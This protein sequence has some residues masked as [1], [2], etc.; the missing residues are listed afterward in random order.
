[1][2]DGA[3]ELGI[4]IGSSSVVAAICQTGPDA[5][6]SSEPVF[7][8]PLATALA[9]WTAGREL[10]LPATDPAISPIALL[11]RVGDPI[12]VQVAGRAAD[13]AD[14][15]AGVARLLVDR[16]TAQEG[17]PPARTAVVVPPSWGGHRRT[18]LVT[19]LGAVGLQDAVLVSAAVA[20]V[21]AHVES[22]ELP[23]DATAVVVDLGA[24]TSDVAVV[25]P[26]QDGELDHRAAPAAALR[27][28]GRDVDDA[29][30]RHVRRCL[31]L[32]TGPASAADR[33]RA[34]ALRAACTVAK[35]AAS[36]QTE[37]EVSVDPDW[38]ATAIRLTREELEGAI[39]D[40][41]ERVV[42][43]AIEAVAAAVTTAD[44]LSGV[45]LTGGASRM[46]LVAECLSDALAVPLY[47]A[48]D[49]AL[50]NARG[51]A[52][53]AADLG[54]AEAAV[55]EDEAVVGS[56][57]RVRHGR[58]RSG[59]ERH[60]DRPAAKSSGRSGRAANGGRAV[61][62]PA[63]VAVV[64]ALFLVLV[65]GPSLALA[66]V[67]AGPGVATDGTAAAGDKTA[68]DPATDPA[69]A[70]VTPIDGAA[71]TSNAGHQVDAPST[72]RATTHTTSGR[73][74]SRSSSSR[75]ASPATSS[76]KAATAATAGTATVPVTTATTT[77]PAT[78]A[79]DTTTTGTTTSSGPV[80]SSDPPPATTSD[81]PP[82]TSSDPP[83]PA[84]SSAPAPLPD[85]STS[86][87]STGTGTSTGTSSSS[88]PASPPATDSTGATA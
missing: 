35:E 10:A 53:V 1:M 9:A 32:P 24:A 51:A 41:V 69:G 31:E 26:R 48:T 6:T 49:P 43:T 59:G 54:P 66:L 63:R 87:S 3:Y 56:P 55:A 57:A 11:E 44:E 46:P 22:G 71:Q 68:S 78:T 13:A 65:V 36:T 47:V 25:G 40:D 39:A 64:A 30:L 14:V 70:P 60:A 58:G 73:T 5:D 50:T 21:R 12:S 81:P 74:T 82:V 33:A 29:V 62:P 42:A 7:H 45:V 67:G 4:D 80:T 77:T 19:A 8:A 52:R 34:V 72:T 61:R 76:S 84:S 18:A 27:W 75:T 15:V 83:P 38:S 79:V 37:V 2:P 17:Q 88:A 20:A 16:V 85:P 23:A 86:G 28:G